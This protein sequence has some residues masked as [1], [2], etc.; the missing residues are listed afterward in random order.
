MTKIE[1]K[2]HFTY[3]L[4]NYNVEQS[5]MK[6]R[7]QALSDMIEKSVGFEHD[8]SAIA[9]Q[10]AMKEK[11]FPCLATIL[12]YIGPL[13]VLKTNLETAKQIVDEIISACHSPGNKYEILGKE[14]YS[15]MRNVLGF[16]PI[17]LANGTVSPK[18]ERSRWIGLVENYLD[19]RGDSHQLESGS[20]PENIARIS[21]LAKTSLKEI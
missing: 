5:T 2:K 20:N 21:S 14:K 19:H 12:E 3:L 9:T 16:I 8:W 18:F 10:I 4:L 6:M 11:F 7:V 17:D 1:F 13:D 15:I